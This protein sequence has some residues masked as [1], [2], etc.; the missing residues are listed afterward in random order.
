MTSI[1]RVQTRISGISTFTFASNSIYFD[2]T[3]YTF[4]NQNSD[5]GGGSNSGAG[6][7]GG[8]INRP[9]L[10]NFS[11]GRI[12]LQGRSELNQYPFFGQNGVLG[13]GTGSLVTRTNSLRSK[14]YDI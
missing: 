8:F 11:W 13:I 5:I 14:N 1:V 9:F 7:T 6:Y 3:N 2:S 10:G 4:D 12:E